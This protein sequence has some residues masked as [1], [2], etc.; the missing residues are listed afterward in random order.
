[1][2]GKGATDARK[3]TDDPEHNMYQFF[4]VNGY[5]VSTKD[6]VPAG[7]LTLDPCNDK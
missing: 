2:S 3:H 5:F 6:V 7:S 1:M 4:N